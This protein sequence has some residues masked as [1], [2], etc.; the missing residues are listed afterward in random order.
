MLSSTTATNNN[1]RHQRSQQQQQRTW[2]EHKSIGTIVALQKRLIG[3]IL[4]GESDANFPVENH[5]GVSGTAVVACGACAS[6]VRWVS[7]GV[8]WR[9]SMWVLLVVAMFCFPSSHMWWRS[10]SFFIFV[11]LIACHTLGVR[12]TRACVCHLPF[13]RTI[14]DPDV[15][16]AT[17][18]WRSPKG[19]SCVPVPIASSL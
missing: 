17:A 7:E 11:C 14:V 5:V 12:V 13:S 4:C 9:V 15:T 16:A 18:V 6:G 1:N 8:W 10:L 2:S 3:A 19:C